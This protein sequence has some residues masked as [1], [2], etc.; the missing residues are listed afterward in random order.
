MTAAGV[1][2]IL[3]AIAAFITAISGVW[4][5]AK[6][7]ASEER[8]ERAERTSDSAATLL[9]GWETFQ[10]RTMDEVDRVSRMFEKRIT[11]LKE[12]H[13][14]DRAE[15]SR[16]EAQREAEWAREKGEMQARIVALE[17]QV[18]RLTERRP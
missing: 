16:R 10:Q 3:G 5:A 6:R 9:G 14:A 17:N 7:S 11:E 4:W 18:M 8:K 12:E 15:W 2:T 13:A 1:A